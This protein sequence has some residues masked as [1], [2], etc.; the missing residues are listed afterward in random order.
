M[1]MKPFKTTGG[2]RGK[3]TKMKCVHSVYVCVCV[4]VRV[5]AH[6][7]REKYKGRVEEGNVSN[8]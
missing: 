3:E 6:K 2:Y 5:L 8:A 7:K 1:G 4:R